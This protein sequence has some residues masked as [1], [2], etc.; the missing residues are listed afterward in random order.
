MLVVSDLVLKQRR[1]AEVVFVCWFAVNG[2]ESVPEDIGQLRNLEQLNLGFNKLT[3]LP[4]SFSK[5]H[6]LEV[7]DLRNN[8]FRSIPFFVGQ[9]PKL[10]RLWVGGE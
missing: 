7:L 6:N 8:K 9:L 5:L 4:F 1:R 2:L 3:S 10:T